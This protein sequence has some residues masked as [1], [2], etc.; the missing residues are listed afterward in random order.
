MS[1]YAQ[2][3]IYRYV[4]HLYWLKGLEV[5]TPSSNEHTYNPD[6]GSTV[7]FHLMTAQSMTDHIYHGGPIRL[8]LHSLGV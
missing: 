1:V 5:I 2:V 3:T 8:V 6:F 7:M 4:P